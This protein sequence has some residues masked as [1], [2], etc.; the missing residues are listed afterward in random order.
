MWRSGVTEFHAGDVVG[1]YGSKRASAAAA[2]APCGGPA[3]SAAAASSP[4]S[5]CPTSPATRR[6]RQLAA[7]L[8]L[9]A[10]AAASRSPHVVHVLDGGIDPVPYVAMEFV[11]GSTLEEVLRQRRRLSQAEVIDIGLAVAEALHELNAVGVIH[12]DVKPSNV[13]IDR[14]GDVRLTDFGIA[15]IVGLDAV[16]V[17]GQLPLSISYA[18]PEVW[19]GRAEHRS[20]LYALGVVLYQCLT[21]VAALPRR[22]CGDVLSPSRHRAG[23]RLAAVRNRPRPRG[24]D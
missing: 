21:G 11:A 12:R 18:A 20:D 8:E 5:S 2:S 23:L 15:K 13:M 9:L 22:L 24:P 1:A 14:D 7:D 17:T 4:S 16:T 10:G 3:R 6:P 19:E